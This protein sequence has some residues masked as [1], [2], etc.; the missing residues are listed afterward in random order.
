MR[1]KQRRWWLV[2]T[3]LFMLVCLVQTVSAL[4][5]TNLFIELDSAWEFADPGDV[6]VLRSDVTNIGDEVAVSV[7]VQMEDIP[8]DWIVIPLVHHLYSIQPGETKPYFFIVEKGPTD[9]T[10]FASAEGYNAPLVYS[11]S[12]PIPV[13]PLTILGLAG[14]I[15]VAGYHQKKRIKRCA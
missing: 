7:D 13:L 5:Q 12:I 11:N 6:F 1:R 9:A 4:D 10:V 3:G 15:G 8:Q 2:A 14:I